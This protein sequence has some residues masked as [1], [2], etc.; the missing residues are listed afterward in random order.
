MSNEKIYI[1]E[2]LRDPLSDF[3][4]GNLYTSYVRDL[5]PLFKST[6][7]LKAKPKPLVQKPLAQPRARP[8]TYMALG[9]RL[10]RI[11][12]EIKN[13]TDLATKTKLI[14]DYYNCSKDL[15]R[16]SERVMNKY[17]PGDLNAQRKNKT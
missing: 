13:T 6:P 9:Q 10:G 17:Q 5:K 1:S 16:E 11:D 7:K 3:E 14:Q 15:D 4:D 8:G 12:R 2:A